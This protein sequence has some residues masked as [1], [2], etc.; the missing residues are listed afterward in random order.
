MSANL[1]VLQSKQLQ[2]DGRMT[3]EGTVP[4]LMARI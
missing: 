2:S 1:S 4:L 3:A